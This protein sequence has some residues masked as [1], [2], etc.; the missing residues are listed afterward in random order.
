MCL[1]QQHKTTM[2]GSH[3]ILNQ[4][5]KIPAI[6]TNM[7]IFGHTQD[8]SFLNLVQRLSPAGRR[9]FVTYNKQKQYGD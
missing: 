9:S 7:G 6:S 3:K 1:F 8:R 5:K 2:I 4:I